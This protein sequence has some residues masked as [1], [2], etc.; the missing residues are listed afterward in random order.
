MRSRATSQT[1]SPL[2]YIRAMRKPPRDTD[3]SACRLW[4]STLSQLPIL[5][6]AREAGV[7]EC[8]PKGCLQ[9]P[10]SCF[11]S[12]YWCRL[13]ESGAE[14]TEDLARQARTNLS[15]VEVQR[16][17][18][19]YSPG[20]GNSRRACLRAMHGWADKCVVLPY[21]WNRIPRVSGVRRMKGLWHREWSGYRQTLMP[22][23]LPEA[24]PRARGFS[25]PLCLAHVF[26]R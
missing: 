2:M 12:Q 20:M 17:K 26:E 7:V 4:A 10:T 25:T 16:M 3:L 1:V 13:W 14:A 6:A 24:S 15:L 22:L 11:L 5:L 19:G 18:T 21:S 8:S 23:L 9:A